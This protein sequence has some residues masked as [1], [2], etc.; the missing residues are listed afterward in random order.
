[1]IDKYNLVLASCTQSEYFRI[2]FFFK[3]IYIA[4]FQ[5]FKIQQKE[6]TQKHA[7]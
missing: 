1:M 6:K 7:G 2:W 3:L 4:N 5:T